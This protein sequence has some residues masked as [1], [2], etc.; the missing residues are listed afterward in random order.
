MKAKSMSQ[1]LAEANSEK[2]ELH[3][4]YQQRQA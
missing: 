3:S 1:Q 4:K 2:E